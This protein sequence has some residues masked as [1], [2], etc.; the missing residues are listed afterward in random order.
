M[1]P[2]LRS[3]YPPYSIEV[4]RRTRRHNLMFSSV[5]DRLASEQLCFRMILDVHS[6]VPRK[7]RKL[8]IVRTSDAFTTNGDVGD[9]YLQRSKR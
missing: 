4:A 3:R 2:K 1:E 9:V 8:G 5:L 7:W 6:P